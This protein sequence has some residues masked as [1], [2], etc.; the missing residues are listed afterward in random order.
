VTKVFEPSFDLWVSLHCRPVI[1][2]FEEGQGFEIDL[3]LGALSEP[4]LRAEELSDNW[5]EGKLQ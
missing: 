2:G 3:G 5:G 4:R 1:S